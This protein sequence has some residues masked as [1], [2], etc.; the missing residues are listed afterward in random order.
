MTCTVSQNK[1]MRTNHY[2]LI[3]QSDEFYNI[4]DK[5]TIPFLMLRNAEIITLI[6]IQIYVNRFPKRGLIH[7]IINI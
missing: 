6:Y 1:V 2:T 7:A 5:Q 4:S 3:E